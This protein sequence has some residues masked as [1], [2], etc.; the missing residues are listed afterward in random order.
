ML[1]RFNDDMLMHPL[2]ELSA[3]TCNLFG[4]ETKLSEL[5]P[6]KHFSGIVEQSND[7]LFNDA[8]FSNIYG[9][10]SPEIEA[11]CMKLFAN[12]L[13]SDDMPICTET[14]SIDTPL[15]E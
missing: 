4:K 14:F 1:E 7:T 11:C 13:S 10:N 12:I 15:N 5:H 6:S 9:T 8:Q 2:N 3:M